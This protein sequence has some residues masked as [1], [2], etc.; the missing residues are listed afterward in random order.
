M[1]ERSKYDLNI[2]KTLKSVVRYSNKTKSITF[3]DPCAFQIF[4]TGKETVI[5][6]EFVESL[7]WENFFI[8]KV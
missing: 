5:K 3:G 4:F 7:K 1:T 2:Y 6:S 8:V